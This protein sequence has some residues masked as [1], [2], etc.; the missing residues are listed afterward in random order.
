MENPRLRMHVAYD[1][2]AYGTLWGTTRSVCPGEYLQLFKNGP[3][4]CHIRAMWSL[5]FKAMLALGYSADQAF[6]FYVH[7]SNATMTPKTPWTAKDLKYS[8]RSSITWLIP[9]LIV[10][11]VLFFMV[12]LHLRRNR[13]EAAAAA[14]KE[15]RAEL[16][17]DDQDLL[18]E[19]LEI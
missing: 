1:R 4:S 7:D 2:V 5:R 14:A 8:G 19:V 17:Q 3:V 15:R 6:H 16:S 10:V 9:V 13:R 11:G 12:A 18:D